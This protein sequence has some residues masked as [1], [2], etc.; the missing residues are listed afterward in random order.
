MAYSD[1]GAA[2]A[3]YRRRHRAMAG[4]AGSGGPAAEA[5]AAATAT[6]N[7]YD[8]AL[9]ELG[10]AK[11]TGLYVRDNLDLPSQEREVEQAEFGDIAATDTAAGL[12]DAKGELG[13]GS[14]R[15]HVAR[16]GVAVTQGVTAHKKAL[17]GAAMAQ[18]ATS[19]L[20]IEPG[21][22]MGAGRRQGA[23]RGPSQALALSRGRW[24]S[25]PKAERMAALALVARP[26]TTI[27]I[28]T[29]TST[30]TS[31]TTLDDARPRSPPAARG[32]LPR[33]GVA[34]V[35]QAALSGLAASGRASWR[36]SCRRRRSRV[37]SPRPGGAG[38]HD[39][40]ARPARSDYMEA[41]R[42]TGVRA[43]LRLRPVGG[44]NGLLLLPAGGQLTRKNNNFA[45]IGACDK[46]K[47]GWSSRRQW[48]GSSLRR[49]Y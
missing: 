49:S 43:E 13:G 20:G 26:R 5:K 2:D 37:G 33:P 8:Q 19:R 16:T 39:G 9:C 40:A 11:Y 34:M 10:I 45:G 35:R 15:L 6:V 7:L 31:T 21:S 29:T 25:R 22:P 38:K 41:G 14:V 32:W 46:C 17:L 4:G 30:S 1:V 48:T 18:L 12:S 47:H 3:A 27:A 42:L 23:R 28:P 24:R 36:T 44:R